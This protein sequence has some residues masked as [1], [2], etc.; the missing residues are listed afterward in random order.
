MT[1]AAS[2]AAI[3][4]TYGSLLVLLALWWGPSALAS[5]D[6]QRLLHQALPLDPFLFID[7]LF[8]QNL[9][10][11]VTCCVL[12]RFIF[13][14]PQ[15]RQPHPA[16]VGLDGNLYAL[17]TPTSAIAL[18]TSI[19]H[20]IGTLM[21][22]ASFCFLGST[23]TQIFKLLEPI[24]TA[25]L[26][27]FILQQSTTPLSMTGI[28]IIIAGVFTFSNKG[29]TPLMA[30][31][32]FLASLAYPARNVL[33]KKLDDSPLFSVSLD[34]YL[35]LQLSSLPL[36]CILLFG[37]S[38]FY[39]YSIMSQLPSLVQN[40]LL[41]NTYQLASL[42]ILQK[43]DPVSH[44]IAN[45][46][47]RSVSIMLS[48]ILLKETFN[49]SQLLGFVVAILGFLVYLF[50]KKTKAMTNTKDK[51]SFPLV[52]GVLVLLLTTLVLLPVL[53]IRERTVSLAGF[54]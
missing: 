3:F 4:Y 31:P 49:R 22:N 40:A 5:V 1:K 46:F 19:M 38:I 53:Y 9:F 50:G 30:S 47:K 33:L 52:V 37:K 21:T 42:I 34:R 48:V 35:Q 20:T 39:Q 16:G 44:S 17:K 6:A 18:T 2:R 26:K 29:F 28:L 8:V 32:I 54:D 14:M 27:Y 11:I 45:T 7:L 43:L 10:A 12:Q 23:A 15:K 24:T 41:Y 25:I 36:T 51:R 13:F